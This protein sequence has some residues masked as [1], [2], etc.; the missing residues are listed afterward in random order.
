M[1]APS[2][3]ARIPPTGSFLPDGCQT[4]IAPSLDP[5]VSFWEKVVQPPG[6]DNGDPI[7]ITTMHNVTWIT[8]HSR[9]HIE[10]T[11]INVTAAWDPVFYSQI[12][13]LIGVNMSWTVTLPNNDAYSVWAYLRSFQPQDMVEGEQ[14]EAEIVIVVTN[15]DPVNC[16]EA[17]P[18]FTPA[19]GTFC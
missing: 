15:W 12:N 14:P 6:L 8:K 18:V 13:A 19:V 11:D 2:V 1:A 10:I 16:V 9:C 17:G 5:D 7:N 3:T 4:L